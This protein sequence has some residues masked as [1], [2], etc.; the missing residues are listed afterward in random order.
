MAPYLSPA[1]HD[2]NGEWAA[3]PLD[4]GG[5]LTGASARGPLELQTNRPPPSLGHEERRD[6]GFSAYQEGK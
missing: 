1:L 4:A 3:S 6:A 5:S 2:I